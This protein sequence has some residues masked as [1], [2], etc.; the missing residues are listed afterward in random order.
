VEQL[1]RYGGLAA[2]QIHLHDLIKVANHNI[3]KKTIKYQI[4]LL[5]G[6]HFL[7]TFLPEYTSLHPR[8]L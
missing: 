4:L 2:A 1:I 5:C 3:K 8:R 6:T 7:D